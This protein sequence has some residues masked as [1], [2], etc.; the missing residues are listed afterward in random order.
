MIQNIM[1]PRYDHFRIFFGFFLGKNSLSS[2]LMYLTCLKYDFDEIIFNSISYYFFIN[3]L[4]LHTHTEIYHFSS[5]AIFLVEPIPLPTCPAI[6]EPLLSD[7][8]RL[9]C[10]PGFN[11]GSIF[12]SNDSTLLIDLFD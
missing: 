3:Q 12:W 1:M 7:L 11:L 4:T 2:T 6:V 8:W 5:S 9:R 10:L